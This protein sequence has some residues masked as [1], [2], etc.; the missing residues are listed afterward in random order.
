MGCDGSTEQK[1]TWFP[2]SLEKSRLPPRPQDPG[3][4]CTLGALPLPVHRGRFLPGEITKMGVS[5]RGGPLEGCIESLW[6]V[7]PGP[8][9]VWPGV[10]EATLVAGES[11][12]MNRRSTRQSPRSRDWTC[13]QIL[14]QLSYTVSTALQVYIPH[15]PRFSF[16]RFHKETRESAHRHERQTNK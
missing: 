15:G 13:T 6:P 7:T 11:L 4:K 5:V 3:P 8:F 9:T 10:L 12:S 16:L 2:E 14:Q 1:Q